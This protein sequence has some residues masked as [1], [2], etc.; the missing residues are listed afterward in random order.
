MLVIRF[1]RVGKKN[2]AYFRIVVQEKIHTPTG[3]HTEVLGSW[4]P[5][6]KKAVL[7]EEKI[8]YWLEKGAQASDSVYNLLVK[9]GVIKGKKRVIKIKKKSQADGNIVKE[10]KEKELT[11]ETSSARVK[12]TKEDATQSK[13][14]IKEDIKKEE[15]AN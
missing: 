1:S 6:L 8:K 7:K 3:R 4:D 15:T 2:K 5:H 10:G 14:E 13:E 12:E 9:E 11:A